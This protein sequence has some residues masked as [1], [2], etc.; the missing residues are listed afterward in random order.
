MPQMEALRDFPFAGRQVKAGEKVEATDR[1]AATLRGL[2]W[3]KPARVYETRVM[4]AEE[5]TKPGRKPRN[6][7]RRRGHS[8]RDM[9]A[10][11]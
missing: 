3:A 2:K 6:P 1:E 8:R 5:V 9:Q 10:E 7:N 4:V 11:A